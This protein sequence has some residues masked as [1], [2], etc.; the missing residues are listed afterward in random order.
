MGLSSLPLGYCTNVHPGRSLQEVVAGLDRFAVPI[1]TRLG[2]PIAVG[3]W[4]AAPVMQEIRRNPALAGCLVHGLP[5]RGLACYTMNAFPYGDFHSSRVKEKV[6][7]PDWSAPERLEYTVQCA[8]FLTTCLPDSAEGSIST[9]PLGF[10]AAA[11]PPDF[12]RQCLDQLIELARQLA[13]LQEQTGKTV[14]IAI[15]P[16]P[17]CRIETTPEAVAFFQRLWKRSADVGCEAVVREHLGLC[18]DVCHQAV[19][20]EDAGESIAAFSA[21]GVRIVKVQISCAIECPSPASDPAVRQALL[22]YVEPRYLHQTMAKGG[23]GTVHRASDLTPE[24]V[25][26]PPPAFAEATPWRVH[27]HVPVDAETIGPLRTTR[28]ELKTA[29]AAIARLAETPHLEVETYTWEVLPGESPDLVAGLS[30]EIEATT[31]LIRQT[32]S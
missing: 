11:V 15:E 29:F 30:R 5:D 20:F 14:R 27:F 16:E 13:A 18:Y 23:E 32:I 24:L 9:L 8:Q 4:L 22:N 25:Q 3:L 2:R 6:Y 10:K 7:L 19:E 1:Q 12:D 21:A 28:S 31:E 26:S 17:F